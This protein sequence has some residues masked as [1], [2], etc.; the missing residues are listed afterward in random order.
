MSACKIYAGSQRNGMHLNSWPTDSQE[1]VNAMCRSHIHPW[2]ALK[3]TG[4]TSLHLSF[5][6]KAQLGSCCF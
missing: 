6:L 5:L 4:G 2:T 3:N 1:R